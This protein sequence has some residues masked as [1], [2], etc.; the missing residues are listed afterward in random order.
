MKSNTELLKEVERLTEAN[1]KLD[2]EVQ[3][4]KRIIRADVI[5]ALNKQAEALASIVGV[6]KCK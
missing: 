6:I 2:N 4:L 5:K 1:K 3:I